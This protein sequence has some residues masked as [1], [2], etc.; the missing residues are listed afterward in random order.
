MVL[1][2]RFPNI[3]PIDELDNLRQEWQAYQTADL[4]A[5]SA[6]NDED[7]VSL[8]WR[9][10]IKMEGPDGTNLFPTLGKLGAALL[11]IPHSSAGIERSFSQ[12]GEGKTKK[13]NELGNR[14]M[15]STMTI[16]CNKGTTTCLNFHP[17]RQ[18]RDSLKVVRYSFPQSEAIHTQIALKMKNEYFLTEFCEK[19]TVYMP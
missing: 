11:V 17:S 14:V 4:V 19:P 6:K 1:G 15:N 5:P 10:V 3:V 8:H 13:R 12:M 18:M 2:R 7:G 9:S 16:Q